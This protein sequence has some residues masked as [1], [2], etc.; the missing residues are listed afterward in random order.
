[1]G[2][3]ADALFGGVDALAARLRDGTLSP[4]DLV[5]ASLARAS[6]DG[7]GCFVTVTAERARARARE[8][9]SDV[10]AGR[11]RGP[12][13]GIPFALVDAVDTAGVATTFGAPPYRERVPARDATLVA[14]LAEAGAILVGK[15]SLV[16]LGGGLGYSSAASALPGPCRTP[17]DPA[18]WAGGASCGPAAA[19]AAGIVPFAIGLASLGSLTAPAASC[20]VT[21]LRPTYGV[22]PRHGVL[23]VAYTLDALGPVARTAADCATVLSVLAGPDAR[24]P[25]SVSPPPG[26]EQVRPE[27]PRGLR[28]ALLPVEQGALGAARDA[29][30]EAAGV[31]RAAGA[32]VEEAALPAFPYEDV[33]RLVV[34]AE[35]A[36]AFEALIRSGRTRE[37]ADPLH[38]ARAPADYAPR[39][40]SA[41]YVRAMRL[42]AELQRAFARF[43]ERHDLVLAANRP[44][45]PP[46]VDE[47]LAALHVGPG[48]LAAAGG[49][50]GLPA[51]ALPAGFAAGLPLSVQL[52]GPA[53]EEARLLSA[54]TLFQSRTSHHLARP[55]L[56]AVALAARAR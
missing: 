41:D 46:R 14:R 56:P 13:H 11:W 17:W 4:V 54:A 27:L 30:A 21:A 33:A 9:A 36:N 25:S 20:G 16:E 39:A 53:F 32:L 3:L 15:L 6:A 12:L 52:V 26:L 10:A 24:D 34:E 23:P 47:P 37:L 48:A 1:M 7:L 28:V 50:A 49:L 22:L 38:R 44:F 35:A 40:T 51:L 42:R 2:E 31:L 29:L 8:V 19:V 43:F 18:R 45:A 55:P 5:E